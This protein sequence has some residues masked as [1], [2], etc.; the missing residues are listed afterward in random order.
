M[1]VDVMQTKNEV[2]LEQSAYTKALLS[3]FGMDKTNSVATPVDINAD[4]VTTSDEVEECDK[5]LFLS[6]VDY[7]INSNLNN[8][9]T[10]DTR[11]LP[12]SDENQKN[13]TQE[14]K[15]KRCSS[16][17]RSAR[18]F[19]DRY[20]VLDGPLYHRPAPRFLGARSMN[21]ERTSSSLPVDV[22]EMRPMG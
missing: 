22:V 20:Y 8:T 10:A 3:R 13:A 12:I 11:T 2:F 18:C 1:G 14:T 17:D 6:A 21:T 15:N 9:N 5:D 4:L 7:V 16:L 19:Q